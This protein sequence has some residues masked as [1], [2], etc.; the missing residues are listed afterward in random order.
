MIIIYFTQGS[1]LMT[2]GTATY[3]DLLAYQT[4][5]GLMNAASVEGDPSFLSP[6][7]LHVV[8]ALANNA[9]DNSAG[10]TVDIDGEARPFLGSTIVDIGADEFT[11]PTCIPVSNASFVNPSLDS[12]TIFWDGVGT[13][14]Q[15]E[16]L[17][18]RKCTRKWKFTCKILIVL[19]LAD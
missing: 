17:F 19:E 11:P 10:I 7:D 2:I 8:G 9:G 1:T 15:Y 14:Y 13:S 5:N 12:V 4:A 18:S 16:L 6:T 3:A